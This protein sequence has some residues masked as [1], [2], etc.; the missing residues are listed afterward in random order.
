MAALSNDLSRLARESAARADNAVTASS[1]RAAG[2]PPSALSASQSIM[3][4]SGA[5]HHHHHVVAA[6]AMGTTHTALQLQREV[7]NVASLE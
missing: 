6:A 7:A 2:V 3:S 5:H 1:T 4:S